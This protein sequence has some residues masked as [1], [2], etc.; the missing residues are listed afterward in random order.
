MSFRQKFFSNG[1][2][3]LEIIGVFWLFKNDKKS[4]FEQD[5]AIVTCIVVNCFNVIHSTSYFY[6][7]I[8]RGKSSMDRAYYWEFLFPNLRKYSSNLPNLTFDKNFNYFGKRKSKALLK[9]P[10][11]MEVMVAKV[12]IF[13][14]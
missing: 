13:F 11:I 8:Q 9:L 6:I 7:D 14:S 4:V 5:Q 1:F 12:V 10:A 3:Y 2:L